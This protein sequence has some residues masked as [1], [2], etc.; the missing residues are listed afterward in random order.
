MKRTSAAH[1]PQ[2]A[3]HPRECVNTMSLFFTEGLDKD[4]EEERTRLQWLD[5]EKKMAPTVVNTLP[6]SPRQKAGQVHRARSSPYQEK[7]WE[8]KRHRLAKQGLLICET[9]SQQ[10]FDMRARFIQ[11]LRAHMA[12]GHALLRPYAKDPD[13]RIQEVVTRFRASLQAWASVCEKML[14][15]QAGFLMGNTNKL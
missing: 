6:I 13:A 12:K 11:V 2:R 1:V 5:D 14:V 15:Q 8:V 9:N 10:G 7:L 3:K 4:Y